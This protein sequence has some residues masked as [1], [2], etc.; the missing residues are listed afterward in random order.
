MGRHRSVLSGST[1]R[2]HDSLNFLFQTI[3]LGLDSLECEA[4]FLCLL[5]FNSLSVKRVPVR[6]NHQFF[7]QVEDPRA[8]FNIDS[9]A[10][11]P[12]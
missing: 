6:L 10:E 7:N 5:F 11:Q 9:A 1:T 8:G 3:V 12:F 4:R 2:G